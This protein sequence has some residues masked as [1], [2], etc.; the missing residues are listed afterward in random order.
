[1]EVLMLRRL[2]VEELEHRCGVLPLSFAQQRLMVPGPV[3][4][5][6]HV[7]NIPVAVRLKGE[8]NVESGLCRN[9]L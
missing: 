4:T 8:F 3:G 7:L 6:Q 2:G 1:M 5:R 9:R